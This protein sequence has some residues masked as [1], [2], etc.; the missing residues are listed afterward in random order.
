M[1][2]TILADAI[3]TLRKDFYREN[4]KS[5]AARLDLTT[6]S[7]ARF[8]TGRTPSRNVLER[9]RDLSTEVGY[10]HGAILFSQELG[11]RWILNSGADQLVQVGYEDDILDDITRIYGQWSAYQA[12]EDKSG[13]DA[14][15]YATMIDGGLRELMTRLRREKR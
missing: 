10:T 9:L 13:E 2:R 6:V 1:A 8:E 5:F 15:A 14:G 11:P 4:Q 12:T 7:V 3:R